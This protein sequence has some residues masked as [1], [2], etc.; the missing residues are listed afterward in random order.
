[1]FMELKEAVSEVSEKKME[2]AEKHTAEAKAKQ[3]KL[4]AAMSSQ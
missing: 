4:I 1:M 3:Q 2:I